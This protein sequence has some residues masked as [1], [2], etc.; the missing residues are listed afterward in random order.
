DIKLK[1]TVAA[2]WKLTFR[3]KPLASRTVRI[4]PKVDEKDFLFI[5]RTVKTD[6]EGRV[7]IDGVIPGLSY[8]LQEEVPPRNGAVRM[9]GGNTPWYDAVLILAPVTAD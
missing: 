6:A 5:R 8:Q 9:V 4:S 1:P 3:D 2:D 7:V